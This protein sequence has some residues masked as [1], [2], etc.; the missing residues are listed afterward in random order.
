MN[1]VKKSLPPPPTPTLER[2][3]ALLT[4]IEN[5]IEIYNFS[6]AAEFMYVNPSYFSRL[7]VKQMGVTFSQY[8]N[9]VRINKAISLLQSKQPLSITQISSLCGFSTIRNF[10]KTFKKLTGYSPK[11]L[12][13]NS[14]YIIDYA[15]LQT[16]ETSPNTNDGELLEH[17]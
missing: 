2:F 8:L 4:E 3:K 1:Q 5:N 13:K 14:N 11:S 12:P 7:F 9:H 16:N 6:A 17:F 15:A 10:N